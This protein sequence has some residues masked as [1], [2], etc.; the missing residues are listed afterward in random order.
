[1]PVSTVSSFK[2]VSSFLVDTLSF[3]YSLKPSKPLALTYL[4]IEPDICGN[5]YEL[6]LVRLVSLLFDSLRVFTHSLYNSCK[7]SFEDTLLNASELSYSSNLG[8]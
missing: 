5:L 4:H 2:P 3:Q 6:K 7:S 1:V 8:K